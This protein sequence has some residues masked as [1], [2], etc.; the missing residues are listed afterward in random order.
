MG[1]SIETLLRDMEAIRSDPNENEADRIE[2][3]FYVVQTILEKM[4]DK[5]NS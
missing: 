4:R 1:T 5:E 3:L 2:E